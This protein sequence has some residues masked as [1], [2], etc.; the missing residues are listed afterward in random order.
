MTPSETIEFAQKI[1]CTEMY[2]VCI[3]HDLNI[4]EEEI[5]KIK[6]MGYAAYLRTTAMGNEIV[7]SQKIVFNEK[8]I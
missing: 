8:C 1:D 3:V 7:V 5:K 2:V 4:V 6:D